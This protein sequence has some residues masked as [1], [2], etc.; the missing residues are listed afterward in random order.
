MRK[1]LHL[2]I[3]TGELPLTDASAMFKEFFMTKDYDWWRPVQKGDLVVDIGACVG[4]F[5]CH[6]LDMGADYVYSVEPNKDNLK[7]L[8]GN[9]AEHLI[10]N[11]RRLSV[12]PVHAAIGLNDE[13]SAHVFNAKNRDVQFHTR[14]EGCVDDYPKMS[15]LKFVSD[16]DI[17]YIDY[18]KIDCEGGEYEIFTE[19]NMDYLLNNVG[20]IACEFHMNLFGNPNNHDYWMFVRDKLLPQFKTVRYMNNEQY[21]ASQGNNYKDGCFMVYLTN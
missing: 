1:N 12:I 15:F 6:A 14:Q 11:N 5:T 19:E 2:K 10:E 13:S 4:F 20:H 9:T 7:V 21:V 18:L 16:Y 8:L 3:D 17:N